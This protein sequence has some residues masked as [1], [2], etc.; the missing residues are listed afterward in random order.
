MAECA[1]LLSGQAARARR[2]SATGQDGKVEREAFRAWVVVITTI[3]W[4]VEREK[5]LSRRK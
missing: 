4:G 2:E 1:V 3:G 5:P